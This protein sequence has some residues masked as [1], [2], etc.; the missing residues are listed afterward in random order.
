VRQSAAGQAMLRDSAVFPPDMLDQAER[1]LL[2][3]LEGTLDNPERATAAPPSH[4]RDN[5]TRIGRRGICMLCGTIKSGSYVACEECGFQPISDEELAIA[6][7]LNEATVRNFEQIANAIRSGQ[8]PEFTDK[9]IQKFIGTAAEAR[10]TTGLGGPQCYTRAK[11]ESLLTLSVQVAAQGMSNTITKIVPGEL[12]VLLSKERMLAVLGGM[13]KSELI[14][15]APVSERDFIKQF[16]E[17]RLVLMSMQSR[18]PSLAGTAKDEFARRVEQAILDFDAKAFDVSGDKH[19]LERT[20]I[21][22]VLPNMDAVRNYMT[23]FHGDPYIGGYLRS[24]ADSYAKAMNERATH[25]T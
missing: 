15:R 2:G 8:L 11:T 13:I 20:I 24:L 17:K 18:F 7:M 21:S 23:H 14:R 10:R 1:Q 5:T 19:S 16:F 3:Y 25:W 9:D 4:A 6:V 12:I 22:F